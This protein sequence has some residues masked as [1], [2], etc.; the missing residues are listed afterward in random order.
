MLTPAGSCTREGREIL[1]STSRLADKAI[2]AAT[3]W[4]LRIDIAIESI[5]P[6]EPVFDAINDFLIDHLTIELDI[7][8][9]VLNGDGKP[10]IK[11]KCTC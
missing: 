10:W 9:V 7:R 5:Q 6:L 2:E 3:G 4:E 1:K 8:E 11:I